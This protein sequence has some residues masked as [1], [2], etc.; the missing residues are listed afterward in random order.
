MTTTGS[1]YE[2]NLAR[3][4]ER[5]PGREQLNKTQV[6]AFLGISRARAARLF[7]WNRTGKIT[8]ASL[9]RQLI[10]NNERSNER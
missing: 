6:A 9:A 3:I 7:R 5:Y 2:D 10:D 1:A 4:C 8:L